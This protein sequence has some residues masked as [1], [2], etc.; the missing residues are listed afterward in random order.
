MGYL[1]LNAH[2]WL[3]AAASDWLAEHLRI[4]TVVAVWA[5]AE[6][7]EA[8]ELQQVAFDYITTEWAQCSVQDCFQEHIMQNRRLMKQVLAALKPAEHTA[9]R[10]RKRSSTS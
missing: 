9:T 8:P 6:L 10:K 1:E 7:H 5:A 3:Q 2:G 4:A